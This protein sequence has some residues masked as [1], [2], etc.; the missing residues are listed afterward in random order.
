MLIERPLDLGT[1]GSRTKPLS[2]P[3]WRRFCARGPRFT[4]SPA[5][6]R[7]SG[8]AWRRIHPSKGAMIRVLI[9]SANRDPEFFADPEDL[10]SRPEETPA[11]LILRAG[12]SLLPGQLA[13]S[14][15]SLDRAQSPVTPGRFHQPST[16]IIRRCSS[17]VEP[18]MT[19][20][21]SACPSC[22]HRATRKHSHDRIRARH[23]RHHAAC[24]EGA[25]GPRPRLV[26]ADGRVLSTPI[27]SFTSAGSM[28]RGPS[29]S[30]VPAP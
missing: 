6:R 30:R 8:R 9:A 3:S 22:S 14:A 5:S 15:G 27:R 17:P 7:A 13:R 1:H 16:T 4:A 2:H 10:Q 12:N 19:S 18:S 23:R 28:P 26:A 25:A 24:A 11:L 20:D 29:L 21:S